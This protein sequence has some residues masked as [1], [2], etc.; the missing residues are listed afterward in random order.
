MYEYLKVMGSGCLF[1][2]Q[3]ENDQHIKTEFWSKPTQHNISTN[4][5]KKWAILH[6]LEQC[7]NEVVLEIST[8]SKLSKR[9]SEIPQRGK[10]KNRRFSNSKEDT[11]RTLTL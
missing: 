6:G 7:N 9:W 1:I 11:T 8:N 10:H 5:A 2:E 4:K 3:N